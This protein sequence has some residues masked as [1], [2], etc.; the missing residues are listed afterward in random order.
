[1]VAFSDRSVD[2]LPVP[3][4]D[5]VPPTRHVRRTLDI[6]GVFGVAGEQ[7]EGGQIPLEGA[8]RVYA[9]AFVKGRDLSI[10]LGL[11]A[12]RLARAGA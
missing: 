5:A 1:M 10:E 9:L 11:G 6:V 12:R 7:L 2:S 3:A 8:L 4:D